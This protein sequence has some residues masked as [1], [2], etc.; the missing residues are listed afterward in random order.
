MNTT[1]DNGNPGRPVI[2]RAGVN[3]VTLGL[4]LIGLALLSGLSI[5]S[6]LAGLLVWVGSIYLPF[7]FY[8]VLL[9]G[10]AETHFKAS[11]AEIWSEGLA[12]IFFG[13][14]L[15]AVFIYVCLRYI[16]PTFVA[17]VW[18]TSIATLE[19][20]PG[21][22]FDALVEAF[23][24]IEA[25]GKL[26]GALDVMMQVMTMNLIGGALLS[27]VEAAIITLR[28]SDESRRNRYLARHLRKQ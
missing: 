5:R 11:L 14:A 13:S 22:D 18:N 25:A 26:P 3:G 4:Y 27:M 9:A 8:R 15:Q 6:A 24:Q 1:G 2:Q 16:D 21:H 19:A 28:Y 23:R 12:S 20:Q 17:D 7:F 10:Y